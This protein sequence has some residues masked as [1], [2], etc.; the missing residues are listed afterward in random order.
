MNCMLE[1]ENKIRGYV[2]GMELSLGGEQNKVTSR[3]GA[4]LGDGRGQ[5]I[6]Q[7]LKM[8]PGGVCRNAHNGRC[9]AEELP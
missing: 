8:V 7:W 9:Q 2:S 5:E 3:F 1:I 6:Q 4:W